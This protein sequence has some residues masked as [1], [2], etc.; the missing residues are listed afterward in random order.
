MSKLNL[1]KFRGIVNKMANWCIENW[2]NFSLQFKKFKINIFEM[3][4][5]NPSSL[6]KRN[7]IINGNFSNKMLALHEFCECNSGDFCGFVMSFENEAHLTALAKLQFYSDPYGENLI[8]ELA[9][10]TTVKHFLN[11][12]VFDQTKV[13]VNYTPGTRVFY[14][15]DW[16]SY[17]LDSHLPCSLV[18]VPKIW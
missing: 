4:K 12:I 6:K 17:P 9:A 14:N 18:F 1:I 13:W 2:N 15:E 11:S 16:S 7:T 10:N 3:Q 8:Y 5:L